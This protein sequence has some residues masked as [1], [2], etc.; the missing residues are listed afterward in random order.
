MSLNTPMGLPELCV[1]VERKGEVPKGPVCA[2]DL[3]GNTCVFCERV[4]GGGICGVCGCL[5]HL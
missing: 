5:W 4:C 1:C 2:W 3:F